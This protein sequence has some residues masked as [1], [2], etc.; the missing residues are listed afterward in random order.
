MPPRARGHTG[1]S[2]R[3]AERLRPCL[4][5]FLASTDSRGRIAF[6]PLEF[7]HRYRDPRDIEVSALLAAALAYGRADLFRPKVDALLKRMGPSPAAFVRTLDVAGARELLS[8]FVYRFNVGTDVAVLLL[9]MG[10]ALRELGSLEALFVQGLEARGS[11]HGALDA[12]TSALRDVPM[13][14]LRA[15]LGPERGWQ[16]LLPSPLGAGAAKRLNLFLRWMVRGPDGVDLGIWKRVSPSALL[17]PLDTHIGRISKHLGLTRRNDLSWRTAEEVTASLRTLDASDPVR[18]DFALCH[19]G[20]SG[21]CP[22]KP[23]PD[24]CFR[25]KLLPACSVGQKTV[26]AERGR[27]RGQPKGSDTLTPTLSRRERG[28]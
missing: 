1:L 28:R 7:P 25:C 24:N 13:E 26:K 23:I 21:V 18:F 14:P 19:Y 12:F 11:W 16:H 22:T 9:G 6:D 3:D 5:A 17:I 2:P 8:G 15:A 10:R 4:D 20:M 27:T